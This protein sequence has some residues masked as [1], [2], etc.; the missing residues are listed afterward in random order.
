MTAISVITL[1][2]LLIGLTGTALAADNR[3]AYF[4]HPTVG[5]NSNGVLD[6][7]AV[8][9]GNVFTIDVR[10]ENLGNN[11]LTHSIVALGNR[12]T[13]RP[14]W[15]EIAQPSLPAGYTVLG[16]SATA[17][18]CSF[19]AAGASCDLGTLVTGTPRNVTFIVQAGA[20]GTPHIW[21]SLRVAENQPNQ[22]DNNNSFFADWDLVVGPTNSDNNSTFKLPGQALHLSTKEVA[23]VNNDKMVTTVDVP[24]GFGGIMSIVEFNNPAGCPN[25]ACIGQEVELNVRDGADIAPYVEWELVI[26]GIGAG[27]NKGGILHTHDDGVTVDN[28]RFTKANMCSAKLLDDCIVSYV[29]DRKGGSGGI[30]TIVFRTDTNGKVRAN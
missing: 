17:G 1:A 16:A 5:E 2:G 9:A 7:S 19:D 10:A 29:I 11:S 3:I 27:S 18:T 21:A 4:G 12:V 26:Q 24:D 23:G 28:I 30:T 6:V 20:A 8:T 22:G 14:D 15:D 25:T 13:D